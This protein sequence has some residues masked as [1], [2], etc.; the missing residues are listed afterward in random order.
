MPIIAELEDFK[1][2]TVP[3]LFIRLRA[4]EDYGL[5]D[6]RGDAYSSMHMNVE[7]GRKRKL[8]QHNTLDAYDDDVRFGTR[9]FASI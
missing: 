8:I 5:R 7:G 3:S 4:V 2:S 6:R 1:S 9:L